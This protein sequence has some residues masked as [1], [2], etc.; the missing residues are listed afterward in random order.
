MVDD[1]GN[2]PSLSVNLKVGANIQAIIGNQIV[3]AIGEGND[4]LNDS[5]KQLSKKACTIDNYFTRYTWK[6]N[7][8]AQELLLSILNEAQDPY[9]VL[10]CGMFILLENKSL[11]NN[12]LSKI[13]TAWNTLN[14]SDYESLLISKEIYKNYGT[15]SIKP[16]FIKYYS[17]SSNKSLEKILENTSV[18]INK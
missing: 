14:S 10:S 12:I 6:Q 15:H 7:A 8:E 3:C 5:V 4:T 9:T 2:Y 1:I 17:E 11:D 13:A 16:F 18:P